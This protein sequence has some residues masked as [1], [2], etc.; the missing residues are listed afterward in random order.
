MKLKPPRVLHWHGYWR[1]EVGTGYIVPYRMIRKR[2]A[3]RAA[4]IKYS[5]EHLTKSRKGV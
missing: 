3:S 2:F 5:K 4:A 1:V